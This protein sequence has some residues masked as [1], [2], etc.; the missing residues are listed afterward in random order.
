MEKRKGARSLSEIP[1]TIL[2][3]LNKG[4]IESANL[5][6]WL[7]IN[8]LS[9]LEHFLKANKRIAYLKATQTAI[10]Q[11]KK[12][13]VLTTTECIGRSLYSQ[14]IQQ[15]DEEL[16]TLLQ[17]HTSDGVRCWACYFISNN[18]TL[19]VAQQLKAIYSLANDSHFGVREIAW[20]AIRPSIAADL[21]QGLALLEKW[22][23]DKAENIR[24]FASE[25]TRPRGVWCQHIDALKEKPELA[26]PILEPLKSDTS[27][28]VKD[29]VG[30]WLNDASKTQ[31]KWV[32]ALCKKWQ[33]ESKTK[34]TEY[35]IKKALRSI[36]KEK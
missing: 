34:D 36:E 23:T 4:E 14:S 19:N 35:I 29:S 3:Q 27:K 28:Y 30:N 6:E 15:K 11:L 18:P 25:C 13:T 21:K 12:Q 16:L 32:I 8:Q 31:A 22:C 26:L 7:A 33:K 17:Q 24:R 1:K 2:L 20:M 10:Q 9:L 5:V